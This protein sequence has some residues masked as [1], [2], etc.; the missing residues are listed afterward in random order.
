MSANWSSTIRPSTRRPTNCWSASRPNCKGR[1]HLYDGAKPIFDQFGLEAEI[2]RLL[3]RK[4]FLKSGGS[5]VIDETEALTVIDVNTSKYTG[6]SSLHETIVK[7]NLDAAGEIARQLRLRDIGGIIVIDFIDMNNARDKQAVLK[8]LETA[9]KKDRSRTKIS[10]ISPLGLVE[11]TRKRTGETLTGF[12]TDECPYCKGRGHL[13]SAE[14]VSLV[15]ERDLR[16]QVERPE[17]RQ[18]KRRS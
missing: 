4:V 3:R 1:I 12:M 17:E 14:S 7:T 18:A 11:M 13:P 9:L 8:A 16:R 5:L 6:G 2:D 15:V 10:N